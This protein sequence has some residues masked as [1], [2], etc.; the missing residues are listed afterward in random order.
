[1]PTTVTETSE[2][3]N[4]ELVRRELHKSVDELFAGSKTGIQLELAALQL[5]GRLINAAQPWID[6]QIGREFSDAAV[7]DPEEAARV[8]RANRMLVTAAWYSVDGQTV[9]TTSNIGRLGASVI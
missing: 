7:R 9:A 3:D 1:M 5:A 8:G 4:L 2:L 6:R